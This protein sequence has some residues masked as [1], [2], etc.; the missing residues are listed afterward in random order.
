MKYHVYNWDYLNQVLAQVGTPL[1]ED[2]AT[3]GRSRPNMAKVRVEVDL[4]KPLKNSVFV[5]LEG[6]GAGFKG[7]EQKLEYEGVP[8]YCKMCKL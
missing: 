8:S 5:G 7:Y 3:I 6:L 2:L 4:S 1:K